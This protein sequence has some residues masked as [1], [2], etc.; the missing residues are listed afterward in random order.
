MSSN[1]ALDE[2]TIRE[3]VKTAAERIGRVWPLYNDVAANPL[4]GYE[5]QNFWEAVNDANHLLGGN[6]Y[7]TARQ[8]SE[9][10]N[11]GKID[12][13]IINRL[14]KEHD[15]DESPE[16]LLTHME[17]QPRSNS[18]DSDNTKLDRLMS[19]WLAAFL[20]Q[21]QATWE[22]PDRSKGFY[23][24]WREI[25][26]YD[27]QI[28]GH[29]RLNDL[30]R[31]AT[32]ALALI[33]SN[34]SINERNNILEYHLSELPGWTGYIKQRMDES[35]GWQTTAPITLTQYLAVRLLTSRHLKQV[36]LDEA[37]HV[38]IPEKTAMP[39]ATE[40]SPPL[41]ELWLS[42]WE[43]TYR[44]ELV[45]DVATAAQDTQT[46]PSQPDAQLVFCIDTRSEILRRK[47]EQT[48]NYH[49]HGYAG[50]FGIP[51]RHTS[52]HSN[53]QHNACP[54]IVDPDY[55]INQQHHTSEQSK[56]Y[57]RWQKIKSPIK[58]VMKSLKND[59]IGAFGF[60]EIA[61]S[62]YAPLLA[63]RTLSPLS[64]TKVYNQLSKRFGDP[65]KFSDI[66]VDRDAYQPD[67][68]ASSQQPSP[69]DSTDDELNIE[70]GM[71]TDEKV[72]VAKAAFNLMGW[73]TFAPIVVFTGHTSQTDNNPY[74]SSIDCG[75]CS[76]NS[77]LPNA[78]VLSKICNEDAVRNELRDEGIEIP[79]ETVFI[80]GEHN[81]TTDNVDLLVPDDINETYD[82]K[83]R[84]LRSDLDKAQKQ[85]TSERMDTIGAETNTPA[86]EAK[87]RSADWAEPRPEI[88]LSGTA[89]FVVA[90]REIASK[91]NF[92][93]RAF[94][95]SYDYTTDED[96]NALE[97]IFAG[98][99]IVTKMINLQYY[100]STVDLSTFGSGSKV[101]HNP[102]G[103]FGVQQGNGGDLM[104][105]LPKQ[106]L[107][108]DSGK[109]YHEPLRQSTVVHA[110]VEW[111]TRIIDHN[112]QI[113]NLL[114]NGWMDM[115]VVDP[116]QNNTVFHYEGNLSWSKPN[117]EHTTGELYTN[118]ETNSTAEKEV[119]AD[120]HSP[121]T[122]T[123]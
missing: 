58:K 8:F 85:A 60:V 14:L 62:A 91:V 90:P 45:S 117:E 41:K 78:R 21:G 116:E 6:G 63:T 77:G 50:F 4:R 15:I 97:N 96:G 108:S 11:D 48:G 56:G 17:S 22:M 57:D 80:A 112:A 30:P 111:V 13:E 119:S 64:V 26:V 102:V 83:I 67:G 100:F 65:D 101:T 120:D 113:S 59:A 20:D 55:I 9:A 98:P 68:G 35:G 74:E 51:M 95:H 18:G 72:T 110:P 92:N 87:R 104:I 66:T 38:H 105:G 52:S 88:G 42:A 49:T 93:G 46:D 114:D 44:S 7:P 54:A 106:S 99:L 47:I 34:H 82:K 23:K 121:T 33:L 25:A 39:D 71:S 31:N 2:I 103:K 32:E 76:G 89:S 75:A 107:M 123:D 61:G 79:E 5:Q 27:S 73:K 81:T 70:K 10:W 28:P 122:T 43:K 94:L 109:L 3:Q 36:L 12:P 19:K 84:K 53:T 86:K 69:N 29:K 118:D 1:Q 16:E 115:T 37:D 24:S 40:S